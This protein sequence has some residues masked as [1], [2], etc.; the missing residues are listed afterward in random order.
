MSRKPTWPRDGALDVVGSDLGT[1]EG[2]SLGLH[3]DGYKDRAERDLVSYVGPAEAHNGGEPLPSRISSISHVIC[4][5]LQRRGEHVGNHINIL[6]NG[7]GSVRWPC[8]TK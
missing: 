1:L 5:L 6:D 7:G 3:A 4:E 8:V 2:D